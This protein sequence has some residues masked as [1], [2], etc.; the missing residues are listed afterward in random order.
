MGNCRYFFDIQNIQA[1]IG[2]RLSKYCLG[3]RLDGRPKALRIIRVDK[4]AVDTELLKRDSELRV[5]TSIQR[6][7]SNY[8]IAISAQGEHGQH[9]GGHAAGC[10][11]AGSASLKR[12]AAFF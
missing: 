7:C 4:G 2:N 12:G 3:I 5:S 1:R 6:I 9:F 10:S 11:Q 8:V